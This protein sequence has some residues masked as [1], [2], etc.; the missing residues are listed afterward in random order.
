MVLDLEAGG[1]ERL[2]ADLVRRFDPAAIES[3]VLAL[4]F[5]GRYADGL[6]PHAGLH[7][8]AKLPPWSMAWPGPLIRQIRAIAPDVVHTHS[9]VWYKASLAARRA[10]VPV[11]VHTDHGRQHPDPWTDRLV[12]RLASRRTDCTVAVSETL[13]GQ[14]AKTVMSAPDRLRVILNGVD[15]SAYRHRQDNGLLRKEWGL[16]THTAIIGSLGRLDHIKGYDVMVEAFAILERMQPPGQTALLIAGDG[17]DRARV[18]DLITERGLAGKA[19][20]LGW[21]SD[22]HEFLA[23]TTLFTLTS[24]SEGTSVSLMEA[25]SSEVCPVVTRVGGNPDVLGPELAHRLVPSEDP[26]AIALAWRSALTDRSARDADARLARRRIEQQYSLDRM[27]ADYA[28][29]YGELVGRATGR[30][31]SA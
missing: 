1:L 9:G 7:V 2:V 23:A 10:G 22:I 3:H 31:G 25:M 29:L 6:S 27:V 21:R 26:E 19:R 17:P 5:L 16:G 24:R 11:V 18:E 8:G 15:T 4:R 12:D 14:M 20:V 13:G 28:Q 30:R